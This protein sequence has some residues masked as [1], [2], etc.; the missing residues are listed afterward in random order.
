MKI[1]ELFRKALNKMLAEDE[2]DK[3]MAYT[4][5]KTEKKEIEAY[6]YALEKYGA[7]N[8][9]FFFL[10]Q[11]ANASILKDAIVYMDGFENDK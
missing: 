11:N 8:L 1:K 7:D 9:P 2:F 3:L 4:S 5:V 6:K 10:V